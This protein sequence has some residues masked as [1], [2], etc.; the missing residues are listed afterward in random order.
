MEAESRCSAKYLFLNGFGALA[1]A[2]MVPWRLLRLLLTVKL[3]HWGSG[4]EELLEPR[5]REPVS[6]EPEA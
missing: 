1:A 2:R 3:V 4:L 6:L 5:L